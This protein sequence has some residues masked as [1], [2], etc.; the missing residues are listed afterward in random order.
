MASLIGGGVGL[1]LPDSVNAGSIRR[2]RQSCGN[3]SSVVRAPRGIQ[4]TL[5][6]HRYSIIKLARKRGKPGS[7]ETQSL[8]SR[9]HSPGTGSPGLARDSKGETVGGNCCLACLTSIS[10]L[11]ESITAFWPALT[12]GQL[13]RKL[14]PQTLMAAWDRPDRR[15]CGSR[16]RGFA[17]NGPACASSVWRERPGT[18]SWT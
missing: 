12:I 4:P 1:L 3:R 6:R 16:R 7:R 17:R 9:L 15:G 14:R 10:R 8:H 2:P 5:R 13:I 18:V 11:P